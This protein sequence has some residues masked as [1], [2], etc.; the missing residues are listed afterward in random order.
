MT[1]SFI[2][3]ITGKPGSGKAKTVFSSGAVSDDMQCAQFFMTMRDRGAS[4]EEC[5]SYAQI[6]PMMSPSVDWAEINRVL[7]TYPS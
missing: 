3:Q 1:K 6:G 5:R 4:L 7:D 2:K